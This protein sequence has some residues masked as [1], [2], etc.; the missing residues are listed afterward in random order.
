[1]G[2]R[3]V[4]LCQQLRRSR[5]F[6]TVA[7]AS[8]VGLLVSSFRNSGNAMHSV[9]TDQTSTVFDV[10]LRH[11]NSRIAVHD[12][13]C[14]SIGF[15]SSLRGIHFGSLNTQV[16][17]PGHY[18]YRQC[19]HHQQGVHGATLG[20][21]RTAILSIFDAAYHDVIEHWGRVVR[22]TGLACFVLALDQATCKLLNKL[23]IDCTC[24]NYTQ[25]STRLESAN[26]NLKGWH[27]ARVIAVKER[28]RAAAHLIEEGFDVIMHDADVFFAEESLTLFME[29]VN[30]V[31]QGSPD[32]ELIT[33]DNGVRPVPYDRLNWGFTWIK[34]VVRNKDILQCT[35]QRW[36][37]DI[38]RCTATRCDKSYHA[39]SQPRIN[40]VVEH[41]ILREERDSVCL[42]HATTMKKMHITH[43]T[44][45]T[46]AKMK[47]IC[48]KARG[49]LVDRTV[50]SLA[51]D[52]PN[53]STPR[54]QKIALMN[55]LKIGYVTNRKLEIPE[56]FMS[57]QRVDFC[58]MYD[59][60]DDDA[61][62]R[63]I[64]RHT[65]CASSL[66]VINLLTSPH[67]RVTKSVRLDFS[68]LASDVL[69]LQY[70]GSGEDSVL[71]CNPE[72]PTYQV[73]HMCQHDE[74]KDE[75]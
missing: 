4:V 6:R 65:V 20:S 27:E 1:M 5:I 72:N 41:T 57:S 61:L 66:R 3:I 2:R 17:E 11:E 53:N 38:F 37:D 32:V 30:S 58:L 43:M 64:A 46:N 34:G 23:K 67:D 69:R 59:F 63:L 55:A 13:S 39:R 74:P 29:F 52:V 33:Q 75:M 70:Q 68:D 15:G 35:L 26:V 73:L 48:A 12:D 71:L 18:A 36:D 56:A 40:H 60:R 50:N 24:F 22:H 8:L 47:K 51:Y 62:S 54:Q 45:Y 44:G 7:R 42:I 9:G 16:G 31:M 49:Y 28:F 10:A 19:T 21:R 14:A 25:G